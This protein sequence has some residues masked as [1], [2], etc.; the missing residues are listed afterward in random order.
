MALYKPVVLM[1]LDGWGE[2][3]ETQGNAI[4]NANATSTFDELDQYY[5]KTLLQASGISVGLPWLQYGNSEVGHQTIGT[6]QVTFQDLPR[7]TNS[8]KNGSF[9]QN[10]TINNAIEKVKQNKSKLHLLGLT[11]DGGVHAHIDHLLAFLEMSKTAGISDRTFMHIIT[12][13]RDAPPSSA[14]EYLDRVLQAQTGRIASIAGRY[15]TMDRNNN[16]DRIEKGYKALFGQ[17][18]PE[19]DPLTAVKNQYNRSITDEYIEPVTIVDGSN[20]PIGAIGENDVVIFYNYRKDRAKQISQ[21]FLNPNFDKFQTLKPPSVQFISMIQ[22]DPDFQ[23]E[24]AFPPQEIKTRISEIISSQGLKQLKIAETEKY[25]HVTYFFNGGEETPYANE[26]QILV[27]SKNSAYDQIPEMSAKEVTHKLLEEIEKQTHDFILVNFANPD[28][29]GHTGTYEAGIKAI[30]NLNLYVKEVI[31]RV[32]DYGGC[33]LITADHG[34]VE[35]M[36][37][38]KTGERDTQHSNNPV[39]CWFVTPDNRRPVPLRGRPELGVQGML[40]DVAPTILNLLEIN[41]TG[42]IGMDLRRIIR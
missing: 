2:S 35:E 4:L 30:E 23:C 33:L 18:T 6:G 36:I 7:I 38:L 22:Y 19:T 25:A 3:K 37:N 34:N 12:D 41:S 39:P 42:M 32:L 11:S 31:M 27:P 28:M 16:W 1:I 17:G 14:T 9:F 26:D 5:P 15:F 40:V 13:G 8:I 20:N 10:E 24:I 21:A 29:V